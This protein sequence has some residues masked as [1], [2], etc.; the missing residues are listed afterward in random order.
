MGLTQRRAVLVLYGVSVALTAAAIGVSIGRNWQIGV[1]ILAASVVLLALVRFVGF[2]EYTQA[3]KRQ[4]E[5]IRSKHSEGLRRL[6]PRISAFFVDASTQ[7]ELLARLATFG[8]EA[9]LDF[10]ELVSWDGRL[11]QILYEWHA[12]PEAGRRLRDV[13]SARYPLAGEG[14]KGVDIKFG[15][16][17]EYGEVSPHMDILLQVVA[18]VFAAHAARLDVRFQN[19]KPAE[20]LPNQSPLPAGQADPPLAP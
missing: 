19:A 15:W 9:E 16:R 17:S 1:A 20:S 4:Q 8:G 10:V 13:V 7:D 2:F 18:D 14:P 11:E 5:R 6:M 12:R 3:R